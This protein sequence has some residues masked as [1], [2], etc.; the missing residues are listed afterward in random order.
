MLTTG[1]QE[2][3]L[4]I[5]YFFTAT[6]ADRYKHGRGKLSGARAAAV[7][8]FTLLD[9]TR[10]RQRDDSGG[11]GVPRDTGRERLRTAG[12]LPRHTGSRW[13]YTCSLG[14]KAVR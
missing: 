12:R 11:C 8:H 4:Y 13:V 5:C 10:P 1:P 3:A 6:A 7:F 2:P 9:H 14:E